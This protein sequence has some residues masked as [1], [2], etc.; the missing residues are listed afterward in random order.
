MLA[1]IDEVGNNYLYKPILI[2]NNIII[3]DILTIAE[4]VKNP[5]TALRRVNSRRTLIIIYGGEWDEEGG[6]GG[7]GGGG[8]VGK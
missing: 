7:A 3:I 2:N 4:G 6:G 5:A 8:V 1:D